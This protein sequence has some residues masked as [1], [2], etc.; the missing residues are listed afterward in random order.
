MFRHVDAESAGHIHG[1]R[2]RTLE[3]Q[4]G[5]VFINGRENGQSKVTEKN[6]R[7]VSFTHGEE[8]PLTARK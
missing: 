3:P 1:H 5:V 6:I 4:S 2:A 8:I 7:H